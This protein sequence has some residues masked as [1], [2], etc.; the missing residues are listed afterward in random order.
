MKNNPEPHWYKFFFFIFLTLFGIGATISTIFLLK[1]GE[2]IPL[3][4]TI[5]YILLFFLF[6]KLFKEDFLRF[7]GLGLKNLKK[8]NSPKSLGLLFLF[9]IIF[10][11][12][13]VSLNYLAPKVPPLKKIPE[14]AKRPEVS[15]IHPGMATVKAITP[16]PL[17]VFVA[18]EFLVAFVN[19][20]GEELLFRGIIEGGLLKLKEKISSFKFKLKGFVEKF[21]LWIIIFIQGILFGL[22][23]WQILHPLG[24]EF[25]PL[26]LALGVYGLLFGI[27][28]GWLFFKE[29]SILP[30][31]YLHFLINFL[32]VVLP[33]IITK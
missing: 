12:L 19:C 32:S 33:R 27:V 9:F 15:K 31:F 8:V 21:G 26:S 5:F 17:G 28:A 11:G 29:K 10:W 22:S 4:I 7:F 2:K 3:N 6:P 30:G 24:T 23:H 13:A 20:L 14:L 16:L 18:V 1:K 25:T